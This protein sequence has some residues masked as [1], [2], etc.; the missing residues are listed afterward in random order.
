[1][2]AI[3]LN[4][5]GVDYDVAIMDDGEFRFDHEGVMIKGPTFAGV[6]A[7]ARNMMK[8]Q[9]KMEIPA[10]VLENGGHRNNYREITRP[11]IVTG[12]H[13]GNGNVMYR[14]LGETRSRQTYARNNAIY[15]RFSTEEEEEFCRLRGVKE[16]ATSDLSKW[17]LERALPVNNGQKLKE[18]W[19]EYK[20][21]RQQVKAKKPK[22]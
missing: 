18:Y 15:S 21:S 8:N 20:K 14:Y 1:M 2:P 11:I 19:D 12:V 17:L 7:R 4:I 16:K 13:S 9:V 3:S 5:N 10:T 22:K 6:A